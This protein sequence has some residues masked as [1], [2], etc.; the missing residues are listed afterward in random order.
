MRLTSLVVLLL[1]TVLC[2]DSSPLDTEPF[3]EQ[4]LRSDREY[5]VRLRVNS[6]KGEDWCL[7]DAC[8]AYDMCREGIFGERPRLRQELTLFV[9]EKEYAVRA[10]VMKPRRPLFF[11]PKP[12]M[13]VEQENIR[14]QIESIMF[15]ANE[16]FN[17]GDGVPV[18]M[19]PSKVPEMVSHNG[20]RLPVLD[21]KNSMLM[22]RVFRQKT[23]QEN[24]YA[25][26]R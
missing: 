23:L 16:F 18:E 15:P 10:C 24:R 12:E 3:R 22:T 26:N 8:G 11:R 5:T 25:L 17:I 9:E 4:V 14:P 7:G 19:T 1:Q 21:L 13:N 2:K 20:R 6:R